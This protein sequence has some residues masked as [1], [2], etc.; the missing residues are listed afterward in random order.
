MTVSALQMH[1]G[2]SENRQL[3]NNNNFNNNN[4]NNNNI[5]GNNGNDNSNNNNN[6]NTVNSQQNINT[7]ELN[8][9]YSELLSNFQTVQDKHLT[10]RLSIIQQKKLNRPVSGI[11]LKMGSGSSGTNLVGEE[12]ADPG[13]SGFLI[14][15]DN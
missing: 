4:L 12:G 11:Y 3:N 15:D 1:V 6:N 9:L 2:F 7:I 10:F 8:N 13:P 5:S 14:P